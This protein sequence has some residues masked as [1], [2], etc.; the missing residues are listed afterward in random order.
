MSIVVLVGN[1]KPRSRTYQAAHLVAEQLAASMAILPGQ[2]QYI[3]CA[4]LH[5]DDRINRYFF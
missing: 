2:R 1:P 3:D 5:Y 4:L